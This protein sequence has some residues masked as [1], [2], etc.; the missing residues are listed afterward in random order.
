MKKGWRDDITIYERYSSNDSWYTCEDTLEIPMEFLEEGNNKL[1]AKVTGVS[2]S[3]S[4]AD[5]R[6]RETSIEEYKWIIVAHKN[7]HKP[8]SFSVKDHKITFRME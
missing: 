2:G 5:V 4:V 6:N 3:G 8:Y 7:H 1:I